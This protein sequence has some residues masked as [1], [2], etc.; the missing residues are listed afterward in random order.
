MMETQPQQEIAAPTGRFAKWAIGIFFLAF[1]I[2]L[3]HLLQIRHEDF[4][5]ILLG[6]GQRYNE[7]A[8][9]IAAGDWFGSDVFYQAPLYPYFLGIVHAIFGDS[10]MM[11]RVV[12]II[13]GSIVCV[14]VADAGRRF[15]SRKAGIIAGVGMALYAPS[16]FFD[17]LIQ[18]SVLDG[19]FIALILWQMSRINERPNRVR[20]WLGLGMALG[21]LILTRENAMLFIPALL[22]WLV[23]RVK[24]ENR[25]RLTL[26]GSLILGVAI[27]LLPV[28]TRNKV[29]GGE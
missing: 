26:S 2:R 1:V 5:T 4:F 25:L 27:I 21:C 13:L 24:P 11:A 22:I 18:K 7:W 6:D 10:L 8:L 17:G 16:I 3:I 15:F 28:A 20:C 29:V 14:L 19:I 9:Q 23:L 12:Q